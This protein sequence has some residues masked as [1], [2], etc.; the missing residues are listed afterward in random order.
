LLFGSL[1]S[2]QLTNLLGVNVVKSTILLNYYI[3]FVFKMAFYVVLGS[4]RD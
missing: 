3:F 1:E 2:N 4:E